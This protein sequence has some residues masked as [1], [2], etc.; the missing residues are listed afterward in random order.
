MS[1]GEVIVSDEHGVP[2]QVMVLVDEHDQ[3]VGLCEKLEAHRQGLLHRA[4][5]VII[6]NDA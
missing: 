5:S 2:F 4:F 3:Q 6:K 1:A